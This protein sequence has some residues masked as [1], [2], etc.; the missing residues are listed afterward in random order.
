MEIKIR[1]N[2]NS[3]GSNTLYVGK[4]LWDGAASGGNTGRR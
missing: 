4:W 2:V 3:Q 1:E